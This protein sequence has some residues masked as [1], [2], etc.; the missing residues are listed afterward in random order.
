[1][2]RAGERLGIALVRPAHLHAAMA[3]TVEKGADL[4]VF[5]ARHQH[6]V[7]AHVGAE[8]VTGLLQLAGVAQEQPAAPEHAR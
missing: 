6:R 1:M 7:L 8:E 3:A 2:I 5:G 4:P